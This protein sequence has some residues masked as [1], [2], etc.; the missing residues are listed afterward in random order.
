MNDR[1]KN[2]SVALCV[3][4]GILFTVI[5]TPLMLLLAAAITYQTDDPL[6]WAMP[7]AVVV[8]LISAFLCG[9]VAA[10]GRRQGGLGAGMLAGVFVTVVLFALSLVFRSE[11]GFYRYPVYLSYLL[12]CAVGGLCG[13]LRPRR[14]R[15]H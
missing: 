5:T 4:R 14:R 15:H 2:L 3:L 9:F 8:L 7:A 11:S 1:K 12:L 10:R 6:S 13:S